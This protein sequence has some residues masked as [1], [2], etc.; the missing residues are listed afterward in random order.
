MLL[1]SAPGSGRAGAAAVKVVSF[2]MGTHKQPF[3]TLEQVVQAVRQAGEQPDVLLAQEIPWAVKHDILAEELGFEHLVSGLK[4][5]PPSTR[6]IFSRTPLKNPVLIPLISLGPGSGTGALCATTTIQGLDV[7]VC[8]VHLET[9]RDEMAKGE[10]LTTGVILKY[11]KN[12][13]FNENIRSRSVDTLI[14]R[15]SELEPDKMIIGGDFNT[16]PF[17]K[18][19]RKMNA[20]FDDAFWL[21]TAFFKGSYVDFSLFIKPRIDFIFH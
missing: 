7:L 5:K 9:I 13:L 21:S 6:A 11:V 17:S 3:P 12:E 20:Q 2:N 15:L 4:H 18:A 1:S 16:F 19:I 10:S 14:E 8:S